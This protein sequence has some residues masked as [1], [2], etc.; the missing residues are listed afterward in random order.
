MRKLR[1]FALTISLAALLGCGSGVAS[2]QIFE[3]WREEFSA[4]TEHSVRASVVYLGGQEHSEF[5]L[6]Y[7]ES[8]VDAAVE[9]VEPELIAGVKASV[10][11]RASKLEYE[12]II[13]DAGGDAAG[14]LSPMTALPKAAEALREGHVEGVWLEES[15]DGHSLF[16]TELQM[17]DG[18]IMTLWQENGTMTPVFAAFRM[19]E[20]V[21]LKISFL[22]FS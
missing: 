12:G 4:Q 11:E 20:S 18:L 22:D 10:G 17:P 2:R 7:T 13:L 3:D 1:L 9:V 16:V 6:L 15:E 5:T 19:G 14:M 21:E 8:G